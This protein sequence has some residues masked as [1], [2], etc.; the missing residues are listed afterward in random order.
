MIH[1]SST[2]SKNREH[3]YTSKVVFPY[4]EGIMDKTANVFQTKSI[5]TSFK[6]L[7]TI[8]GMM[9]LLRT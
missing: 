8:R 7:R 2:R 6:L 1:K 9:N 4:I 5:I 3:D